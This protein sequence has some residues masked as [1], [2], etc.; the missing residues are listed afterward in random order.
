MYAKPNGVHGLLVDSLAE[1]LRL[2]HDPHPWWQSRSNNT[3]DSHFPLL[4]QSP[5]LRSLLNMHGSLL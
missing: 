5:R 2:P 4:C 1:M 3:R